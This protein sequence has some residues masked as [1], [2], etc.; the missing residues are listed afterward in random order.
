MALLPGR[1]CG[2]DHLDVRP[3]N[4][5]VMDRRTFVSSTVGGFV[6]VLT[7]CAADNSGSSDSAPNSTASRTDESSATSESATAGSV[8][9]PLD[10]VRTSWSTDPYAVGSY[11]FLPVGATPQHRAALGEPVRER[12][13]FA[14]EA[15]DL[16]HPSTVHGALSSGWRAAASVAERA[17]PG[18]VVVVVGAGIAGL[19][20]AQDLAAA[21]F[22]VI[23]IEARDRIGGRLDTARP[24][25]WPIPVELGASWI[26]DV[27]ASDLAERAERLGIATAPFDYR[28]S[29]LQSGRLVS[30]PGALAA[31]AYEEIERSLEGAQQNEPDVSIAEALALLRADDP[32]DVDDAT[33]DWVLASEIVT[34]YGATADELSAY[35]GLEE[36][37]DG[38]DLLVLGGYG[39]LATDLAAGL[40]VRLQRPVR[41]IDTTDDGVEVTTD[42]GEVIA[43]GRIVVTVPL[44]VLRAGSIEFQPPLPDSTADA[45]AS[46]GMGLLDKIWFRYDTTFWRDDALMW[47]W[48]DPGGNP[49]SEWF[50]LEPVTG[51]PI[52]LALVGAATAR[53]V[54]TRTDAEIFELAREAL[55]AFVDAQ[56]S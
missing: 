9:E 23:V 45:I 11:S 49:L 22:D 47:T 52:L 27:E 29:A 8:P 46:L 50:N 34:E 7:G 56:P 39:Q 6:V 40:D 25:G 53:D 14:G 54:A 21:G 51:E 35:W 38:D 18:E 13:F 36:G 3:R 43:A 28:Q 30:D 26:H 48:A 41:M 4:V 5:A 20:A 44:G 31:E 1:A 2:S 37:S 19:G 15:T 42:D 17:E 16:D 33:L 12:L 10:M 55:Q 32:G 24:A